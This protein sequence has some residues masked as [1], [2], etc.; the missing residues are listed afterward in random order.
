MKK[1]NKYM[2]I[3]FIIS[4]IHFLLS[5]VYDRI[6][7]NYNSFN[8]TAIIVNLL[9]LFLLNVMWYKII[10]II[11]NR[12]EYKP[13]IIVFVTYFIFMMIM[14]LLTFP[15]VWRADEPTMLS[16]AQNYELG[17]W[18]HIFSSIY[19][20]IALKFIPVPFG[21]VI[22]QCIVISSI[23][24][25]VIND[26][27][28][29]QEKGI[30]KIIYYIILI[31]PFLLLPVIDH[32]LY[33]LRLVL[34]SY[35]MIL[36][37][38][39]TIKYYEKNE[40][41]TLLQ[42]VKLALLFFLLSTWRTEGI[43]N[44]LVYIIIAFVFAKKD[45]MKKIVAI[46]S[47]LAIIV[48]VLIVKQVNLHHGG[49]DKSYNII[50]TIEQMTPLTIKAV[51][52]NDKESL[53]KINKVL[54]VDVVLANKGQKG[55]R[56]YYATEGKSIRNIYTEEEYKEYMKTY[57]KLIIKYPTVF[58]NERINE[59][60]ETNGLIPNK[61]NNS[62][63]TTN[64]VIE[65]SML[66]YHNRR[67][68]GSFLINLNLRKT[69]IRAL[70]CRSQGNYMITNKITYPVFWNTIPPTIVIL[71][72]A[73]VLLFKK[74]IFKAIVLGSVLIKTALTFLTAPDSFFMYYFAEYLIGYLLLAYFIVKLCMKIKD[75]GLKTRRKEET[76]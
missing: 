55:I 40:K 50:A 7:F 48:M 11:R 58:L 43:Y 67:L 15:G 14:L 23:I 60:M 6:F 4:I 52:D 54:N 51:E 62:Y 29:K 74:K 30:R 64:P 69:V 37:L 13:K 21:I 18:Q 2:I 10:Y 20:M 61:E 41:L 68:K 33:T 39:L 22:V 25:Y 47:A 42:V 31:L 38:Y 24:S 66:N 35:S 65:N 45:I 72:T 3:A 73:I 9:F 12:M 75:N 34:Y 27:L 70:E 36:A 46:I 1:I 17:G 44:I 19:Y 49:E 28:E 59:Y 16:M 56:V 26:I 32:N 5:F 76:K 63:D 57:C 8:K 71:I 53:E